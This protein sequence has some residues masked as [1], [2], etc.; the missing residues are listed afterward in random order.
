MK[1][2]LVR[3]SRRDRLE[4]GRCKLKD[5]TQCQMAHALTRRRT[6]KSESWVAGWILASGM[7]EKMNPAPS[8]LWWVLRLEND[9]D[10]KTNGFTMSDFRFGE[11]GT[12]EGNSAVRCMSRC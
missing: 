11:V 10:T 3:R 1:Q 6:R 9:N 12:G 5:R 7:R 2:R 8:S 4:V